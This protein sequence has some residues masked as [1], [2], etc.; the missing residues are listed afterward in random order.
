MDALAD[1]GLV[2]AFGAARGD[3]EASFR[4]PTYFHLR[5]ERSGFH[6]DHVFIPEEWSADVKVVVGSYRDWV[7]TGLSDHVPLIVDVSG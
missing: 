1:R 6:I 4:E 3:E 7:A 2:S 5:N